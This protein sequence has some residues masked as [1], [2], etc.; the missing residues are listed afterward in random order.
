[1]QAGC[2]GELA[3]KTRHFGT[4]LCRIP[5]ATITIVFCRI[6]TAFARKRNHVSW[7]LEVAAG[8]LAAGFS[9]V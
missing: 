2:P 9:T 1:M 3:V 8:Y 4:S 5:V 6:P 7:S